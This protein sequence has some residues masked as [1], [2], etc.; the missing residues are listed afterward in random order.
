M[1]HWTFRPI[2]AVQSEKE[3][4]MPAPVAPIP[5]GFTSVTPYLIVNDAAAALEFYSK[6]FGARPTHVLQAPDGHIR[7]ASFRIGD[8][9]LMLGQHPRQDQQ[10]ADQL[11]QLSVYLY[12]PNS[13]ET[14]ERAIQLGGT[15]IYPVS[16]K[17][18]GNREGG[19]RDPFGITWWI[20]TQVEV[21]ADDEVSR[22]MD[23]RA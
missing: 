16:L 5:E 12:V 15:S 8:A 17:P 21:I 1:I 13:D 3:E 7:H 9:M 22:R 4:T 6:A 20:A 18:Y 23:Q 19:I 10:A 2:Q 14:W 11:P